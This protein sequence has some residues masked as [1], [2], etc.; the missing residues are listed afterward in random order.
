M[1]EG[2]EKFALLAEI[3]SAIAIVVSLVFVGYQI[4]Q[5][6]EETALNTSAIQATI[7]Q[8]MLETD[9]GGLYVYMD[10]PYL[11]KRT[12]LTPDQLTE[13]KAL[14]IAFVRMRE[15]YWTQFNDGLLDEPTWLSYRQ[16]LTNVVFQSE[17]GREVWEDFRRAFNPGFIEDIEEWISTLDLPDL[18]NVLEP[19]PE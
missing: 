5:G 12:E 4:R 15:Y 17:V 3:V 16:P 11:A 14:I 13:V 1:K 18:D 2:L 9:L 7:R 10:H 8:S 6:N 19:A